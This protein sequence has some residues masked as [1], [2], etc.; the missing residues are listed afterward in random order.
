MLSTRLLGL[1][2]T[3]LLVVG[4]LLVGQ[5]L[6]VS[7]VEGSV[8][9]TSTRVLILVVLGSVLVALGY[10]ARGPVAESY[11]LTSDADDRADPDRPGAPS[12]GDGRRSADGTPS[13]GEASFDPDLSPLGDSAPGDARSGDAD[14]DADR[15]R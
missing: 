11:G 12:D 15:E 10:A 4:A 9:V 1:L 6:H 2:S 14:P 13:E 8:P 3:V 5:A 7:L